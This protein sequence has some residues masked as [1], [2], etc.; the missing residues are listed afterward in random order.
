MRESD[1]LLR[2]SSNRVFVAL[3]KR[4]NDFKYHK[5]MSGG[6]PFIRSPISRVRKNGLG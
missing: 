3:F 5:I 4:P 6:P 2:F 1:S